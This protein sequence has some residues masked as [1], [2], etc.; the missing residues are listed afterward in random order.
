MFAYACAWIVLIKKVKALC[1]QT[2]V[3]KV[4]FIGMAWSYTFHGPLMQQVYAF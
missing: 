4:D 1:K 3:F 2:L